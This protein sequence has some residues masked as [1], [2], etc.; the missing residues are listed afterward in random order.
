MA[1]VGTRTAGQPWLVNAL[2]YG[3]TDLLI[4]WPQAGRERRFVVESKVLR[5]DLE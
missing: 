3:R 2:C 1:L 4:V 5:K